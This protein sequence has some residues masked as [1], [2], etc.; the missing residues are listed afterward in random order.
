MHDRKQSRNTL[1]DEVAEQF[2]QLIMDFNRADLELCLKFTSLHRFIFLYDDASRS[3]NA[4]T[5]EDQI[6]WPVIWVLARFHMKHTWGGSAPNLYI[7]S[8]RR[9]TT[10]FRR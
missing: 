10:S 2:G 4:A 3:V 6:P 8:T 9:L 5:E 7:D 1:D